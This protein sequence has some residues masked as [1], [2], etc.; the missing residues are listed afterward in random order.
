MKTLTEIYAINGQDPGL[1][2]KSGQLEFDDRFGCLV[3]TP[4]EFVQDKSKF[5]EKVHDSQA[6]ERQQQNDGLT[7]KEQNTSKQI[8]SNTKR[9]L[10]NLTEFL[11]TEWNL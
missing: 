10:V 2:F 7:G 6:S 1:A 4:P 5:S 3:W 9:Q 11:A 8:Q